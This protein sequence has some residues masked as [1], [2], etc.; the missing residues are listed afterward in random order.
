MTQPVTRTRAARWRMWRRMLLFLAGALVAIG[1]SAFTPE[2]PKQALE[3]RYAPPPSKFLVLPSG[4]R[5]HY[6]DQGNGPVLVLLHGLMSSLHTWEPWVSVLESRFRVITLDLP[7]HGLTGSVPGDD[8]SLDGMVTFL[9]EFRKKLGLTRF[10]LGGNSMGGNVSWRFTLAHPDAVSALVLLDSGGVD[11]LLSPQDQP[12]LPI[13]FRILR[14]PV[15]NRI[16]EYIT[17]RRVVEKSLLGT[18]ADPQ[19][20]TPMMVDR[21]WDLLRYPG[22]RRAARLR[23]GTSQ[24]VELADRLSQIHTPTLILWGEKDKL[25]GLPAARIFAAKISGSKLVSYP[26]IGHVPMEEI[27]ERSAADAMQFLTASG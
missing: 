7:G 22:N 9:D 2:L 20:V 17:P 26:G 6:R 24:H 18:L 8:Y 5:V 25:R 11:H 4:A 23:N 14:L 15:L 27:P 3:A 16:A 19:Q 10:A 21:Y 1:V 12:K 13:G